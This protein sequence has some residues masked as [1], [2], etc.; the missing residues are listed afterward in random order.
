[1]GCFTSAAPLANVRVIAPHRLI[2]ENLRRTANFKMVDKNIA[3]LV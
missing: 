2:T 1:M 3:H